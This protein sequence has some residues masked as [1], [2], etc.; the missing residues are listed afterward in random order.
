MLQPISS[1]TG[2][3]DEGLPVS[4]G[5]RSKG[6]KLHLVLVPPQTMDKQGG[7]AMK[8][9]GGGGGG[10]EQFTESR[11]AAG[12]AGQSCSLITAKSKLKLGVKRGGRVLSGVA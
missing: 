2:A 12:S 6:P 9:G 5:T 10:W 3:A 8:G 1:I 11:I 4:A 7:P